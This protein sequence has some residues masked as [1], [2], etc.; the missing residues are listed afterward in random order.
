VSLAIHNTSLQYGF[1]TRVTRLEAIVEHELSSRPEHLRSHH[2]ICVVRFIRSLVFFEVEIIVCA[3][4][5]PM[6]A[7]VL[8]VLRFTTLISSNYTYLQARH[9]VQA[10]LPVMIHSNLR[11]H[12]S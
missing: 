4:V 5:P 9:I 6:L 8:S 7:I 11:E 1:V 2:N 3:F 12:L 10:L